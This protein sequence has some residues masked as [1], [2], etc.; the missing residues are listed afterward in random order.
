MGTE[1]KEFLLISAGVSADYLRR[2]FFK[3]VIGK[4]MFCDNSKITTNDQNVLTEGKISG[5]YPACTSISC[6]DVNVAAAIGKNDSVSRL[7]D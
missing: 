7:V 1:S 5:V 4:I 3:G 6:R 2:C